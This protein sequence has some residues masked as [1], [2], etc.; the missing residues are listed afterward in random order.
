MASMAPVAA[1]SSAEAG[2]CDEPGYRSATTQEFVT[3][4]ICHL[5]TPRS[6]EYKCALTIGASYSLIYR[7]RCRCLHLFLALTLSL[8]PNRSIAHISINHVATLRVHCYTSSSSFLSAL[9]CSTVLLS[10]LKATET[11]DDLYMSCFR[12]LHTLPCMLQP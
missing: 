10:A 11:V 5:L 2:R 4:H 9:R 7:S 6:M 3:C 12:C 8:L 1:A